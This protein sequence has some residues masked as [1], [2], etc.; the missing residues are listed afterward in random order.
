M[1]YY[2]NIFLFALFHSYLFHLINVLEIVHLHELIEIILLLYGKFPNL[3]P[4]KKRRGP[5]TGKPIRRTEIIFYVGSLALFRLQN[6]THDRKQQ[7]NWYIMVLW[8][9]SLDLPHH[10][11]CLLLLTNLMWN[12]S[13]INCLVAWWQI[14]WIHHIYH[15][16]QICH[17]CHL[18]R[19]PLV[20][21]CV[22]PCCL[23]TNLVNSLHSSDSSN[24]PLAEGALLSCYMYCLVACW[25]IFANSS[26]LSNLPYSPLAKGPPCHVIC[27][28]LL[29]ADIFCEFIKFVKL[30][31]FAAGR[32]GPLVLLC[33]LPC[34][35][36]TNCVNSSDSSNLPYSLLAKWA[37]LSCYI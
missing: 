26:G 29:L 2:R 21:L 19:G 9:Y 33:I 1:L 8:I 24:L 32:V 37:L 16:H 4:A 15:I 31:I 7:C 18:Q 28:A 17:I 10:F 34:C 23:L 3:L 5:E 22:L 30:A 11:P 25:Q 20:L 13:K 12:G 35:F 6:F 14:W 27:T 36:L